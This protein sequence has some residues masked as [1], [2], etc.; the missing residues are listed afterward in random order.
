MLKRPTTLSKAAVHPDKGVLKGLLAKQKTINLDDFQRLASHKLS[1]GVALNYKYLSVWKRALFRIKARK[2]LSWLSDDIVKFG[3]S[4]DFVDMSG[5]FK[6][7]ID[8]VIWKKQHKQEHFRLTTDTSTEVLPWSLIHPESRFMKV[9]SCVL[10]LILLYT[11]TIMP[12]RVAFYDVVFF[13]AWTV[14]DLIMDA[15][16]AFDILVNCVVTYDRRDGSLEKRPGKVVCSYA[17]SWLV[18]DVI[19]CLPFSFVEFGGN[20]DEYG[21]SGS[22][23]Y[24]NLVRLLR[25]PRLYKLLRI[26]RIAKVFKNTRSNSFISQTLDFLRMNSSK[27]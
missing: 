19:A 27:V 2:V 18:F 5:K 7:N 12:I 21:S 8:E 20:S 1:N 17:R 3:T 15:L 25:V 26:L 16:F 23:R 9:W 11:A 24:N 13:D 14:I 10:S 6:L 4:S 22:R